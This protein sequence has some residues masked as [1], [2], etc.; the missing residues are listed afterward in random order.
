LT[1]LYIQLKIIVMFLLCHEYFVSGKSFMKNFQQ[2]FLLLVVL[3]ISCAAHAMSR[4]KQEE[5]EE[6]ARL[7]ETFVFMYG[8]EGQTGA[9]LPPSPLRAFFK[10]IDS[11]VEAHF[12]DQAFYK[13][14]D[15]E[16]NNQAL[17]NLLKRH[18]SSEKKLHEEYEDELQLLD[19]P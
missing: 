16:R 12:N 15:M 8:K 13:H 17:L 11:Q 6:L 5:Q 4:T 19:I 10:N 1:L 7:R 3:G 9:S 18:L 14:D 2:R